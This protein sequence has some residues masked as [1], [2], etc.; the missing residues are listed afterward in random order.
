MAKE[1]P[2]E[3]PFL[4]HLEEL[5]WRIL[6]SLIAVIVCIGLAF[7]LFVK[8]D[9]ITVL[10]KPIAPYL[11]GQKLKFTHPA[12]AFT[13][14]LSASAGLGIVLALPVILF[15]L[16][17]F[18]APALYRHEKKIILP[19]FFFA[20]FLFLSGVALAYF[21]ALP[22]SLRFL[23]TFQS[24]SLEPMITAQS[25][26][27]FAINMALGFGICFEL[28][29]AIL[30]LSAFGI[31][32]PQFLTRVRRYAFVGCLAIAMFLTPGDLIWTSVALALPM[33][34]LYEMSVVIA[35]WMD[36][37]RRKKAE[38]DAVV[39]DEAGAHA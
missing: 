15:Q 13:I 23:L 25:Y 30:A 21:V 20:T 27:G 33:Y 31:V 28:P 26:F 14:I 4:D 1:Q 2:A 36:R 8:I 39:G 6:W 12:E 19:V 3:M 11:M 9:I 32:T 5:R 29:I 34:L 10:Q 35:Y 24:E 7:F 37:R 38:R 22:L 18:V 16:W 17:A